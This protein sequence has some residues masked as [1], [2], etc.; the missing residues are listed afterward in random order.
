MVD[1]DGRCMQCGVE[2]PHRW[3]ADHIIPYTKGG[4]TIPSNGQAL[5]PNCNLK[6]GSKLMAHRQFPP[7]RT[8]SKDL[9]KWQ[10]EAFSEYQRH[11]DGEASKNLPYLVEATPGAGK[12]TFALCVAHFFLEA[13]LVEQIIVVCPSNHLKTQWAEAAHRVGIELYRDFDST[14]PNIKPDYHGIAVT[15][16]WI[17]NSSEDI[18][19]TQVTA[20]TR[21]LGMLCRVPTLV[22]CDEIHHAGEGLAWGKVLVKAF[23]KAKYKLSLSGTPFRGD[24]EK[25]PFVRYSADGRSQ[26]DYAYTYGDALRDGVC[27]Y[28]GFPKFEGE[29]NWISSV[30]GEATSATF[31]DE[32]SERQAA[33]RLNTAIAT[34]G[35]WLLQVLEEAHTELIR[36]RENGHA[37]AGGLVFSKDQD[38]ARAIVQLLEEITGE[39]PTL[40]ISDEESPSEKILQFAKNKKLWLVAVRMV[41]EGVDIPRLRVGVYATNIASPL[42]FK[43]AVGR[44]IR[45]VDG[46]ED[47]IGH[48]YI[49]SD[50]T[51]VAYAMEIKKQR[52]HQI[53]K[54]T[55]KQF[56]EHPDEYVDGGENRPVLSSYTPISSEARAD[57]AIFNE[58]NYQSSEVDIA[59]QFGKTYGID[60]LTVT[61]LLRQYR[62]SL[63][64]D[65]PPQTPPQPNSTQPTHIQEKELRGKINQKVSIYAYRTHTDFKSIHLEWIRDHSGHSQDKASIEELKRKLSW[66]IGKLN[67][68]EG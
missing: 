8:W 52:D 12:T 25:I 41:S 46:I 26:A 56:S 23:E 65:A 66:I 11:C 67:R 60:P 3:H 47:Q 63:G 54:D 61:E 4:K 40:V 44:I 68:L 13:R 59:K 6:K 42:F 20:K 35:Q 36:I 9:R 32:L 5:C 16:S 7:L 51:L 37:D 57:G 45:T 33:E 30:D 48:F 28:I 1:A 34:D 10:Q 2:L 38:H 29:M 22:I 50:S 24:N 14:H 53:Q 58:E 19:V 64:V 62:R 55:Q 39:K 27:R 31:G 43:Q 18:T 49:P 21:K 15:Y 17:T